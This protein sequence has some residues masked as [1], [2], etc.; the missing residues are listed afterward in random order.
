ME[1]FARVSTSCLLG[2]A[3]DVQTTEV[4]RSHRLRQGS[5]NL[6]PDTNLDAMDTEDDT[7]NLETEDGNTDGE[8]IKNF[9]A[10]MD[11]DDNDQVDGEY[12]QEVGIVGVDVAESETA[13]EKSYQFLEKHVLIPVQLSQWISIQIWKMKTPCLK[14]KMKIPC[15]KGPA[16]KIAVRS[17]SHA[18][19]RVLIGTDQ[20]SHCRI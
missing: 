12:I 18:I 4:R 5:S 7:N 13:S 1:N 17:S 11:F 16:M 14:G 19:T 2:T 9:Q 20:P 6:P 3:M 15:L 10:I 8:D